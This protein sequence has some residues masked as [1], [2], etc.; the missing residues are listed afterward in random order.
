MRDT[1]QL[2]RDELVCFHTREILADHTMGIGVSLSRLPRTGEIRS[3][4]PSIDLLS[5]KAF[6]K[7]KVRRSIDGE[8]F[9]H[10]LPLYFGER[11]ITTKVEKKLV[12]EKEVRTERKIDQRERMIHLLR[13][14]IS[15]ITKKDTR[16]ELTAE[17]AME[18]LP[19]LIT[20][21]LVEMCSETKHMSVLAIRRL[22]NF[23]RLFR[24]LIELEPQTGN[25]VHD[26]LK[27]FLDNPEKRVKDHCSNLGDILSFATISDNFQ[28]D[29][30]LDAYLG[31]QLDR[32]VF[33]IL[34]QIPELDFTDEKYRNKGLVME[35]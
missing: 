11:A 31:E 10:W 24:L 20:T 26:R 17:M 6:T 34:R 15:W 23:I 22:I 1:K 3:V 7:H 5:L 19:K 4:T 18:V 27:D 32:Q 14:S 28:L 30:I 16:K 29:T 21:H 25:I 13:K 35:D 9:T 2:L 8:K 33:W 12:D